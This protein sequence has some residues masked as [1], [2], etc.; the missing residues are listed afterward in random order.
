MLGVAAKSK[1]YMDDLFSTYIYNGTEASRSINNG[2]N[3]SSKGGLVWVKARNDSH[4][5]HLVDTERVA[6]K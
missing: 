4:D 2:I 3:L 1:T 5:H 6:T